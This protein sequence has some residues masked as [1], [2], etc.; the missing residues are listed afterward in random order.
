MTCP[1]QYVYAFWLTCTVTPFDL[2]LKFDDN[3]NKYMVFSLIF[4]DLIVLLK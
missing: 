3:N 4:H 1:T 2:H